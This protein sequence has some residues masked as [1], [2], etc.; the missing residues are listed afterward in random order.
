MRTL[1]G[2]IAVT[3]GLFGTVAAVATLVVG[4]AGAI[5]AEQ[6]VGISWFE[7]GAVL[8]SFSTVFLGAICLHARSVM[9]GMVLMVASMCGVMVGGVFVAVFMVLTFV[10]GAVASLGVILESEKAVPEQIRGMVPGTTD[11]LV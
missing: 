1:G 9:A 4:L 5:E 8:V 7:W 6:P 10:G 3:A 2:N 11:Q